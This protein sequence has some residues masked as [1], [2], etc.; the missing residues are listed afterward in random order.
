MAIDARVSSCAGKA[1]VIPERNVPLRVR[2]DVLL[3]EA[4]VDHVDDLGLVQRRPLN[5]VSM[6]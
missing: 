5:Q 2:V 4:E 3:G 1:F 6:L